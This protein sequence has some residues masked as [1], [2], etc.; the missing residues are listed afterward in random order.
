MMTQKAFWL[1][2]EQDTLAF[3]QQLAALCLAPSTLFLQGDLGAG[4]TTL[5]RGFLRGLGF[6]GTVKSPT[7]TLVES[8]EIKGQ[9]ILHFDLYRLNHPEELYDI[10]FADYFA[11]PSIR[12]IEWPER[13]KNQL[14]TADL[15]CYIHVLDCGRELT[16]MAGSERGRQILALL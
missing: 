3:G 8:Y 9:I 12:L 2:N 5:V 7:Y 13:A 4:K 16:I 1:K 10:G 11:T 15:T 6:M 14:P